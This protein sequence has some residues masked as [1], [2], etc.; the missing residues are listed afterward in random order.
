MKISNLLQA[1][2]LL[3]IVVLF[4]QLMGLQN[5]LQSLQLVI[6]DGL[7]VNPNRQHSRQLTN[8]TADEPK[9]LGTTAG[10][11]ANSASLRQIQAMLRQELALLT[12]P[13]AV[14]VIPAV[15][16]PQDLIDRELLFDL[17]DQEVDFYINHGAISNQEMSNLQLEI[18][19]LD[20][21]GKK[22]AMSRLVKAI[23]SGQLDGRL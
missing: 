2:Q 23:N 5:Q 4:I 9:V 14:T 22:Q 8:N 12:A 7:D 3:I 13:P 17:V 10:S 15:T 16:D 20:P 18:A 6:V 21:S 11:P 19:K 1:S